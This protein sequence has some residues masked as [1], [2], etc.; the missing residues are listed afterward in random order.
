MYRIGYIGIYRV[1]HVGCSAVS[2]M[3]WRL[4]YCLEIVENQIEKSGT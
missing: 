3:D 1:L 4:N 2:I